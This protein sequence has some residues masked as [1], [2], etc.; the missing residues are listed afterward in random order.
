[1]SDRN[2]FNQRISLAPEPWKTALIE[3]GDT[4]DTCRLWFQEQGIPFNGA[5]VVALTALVARHA[6]RHRSTEYD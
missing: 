1:M 6:T 4:A 5:D 2:L 3:I